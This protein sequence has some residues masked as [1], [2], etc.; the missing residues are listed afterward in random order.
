[1]VTFMLYKERDYS[2]VST[3][4]KTSNIKSINL[5]GDVH[6]KTVLMADDMIATGGTMLV[7]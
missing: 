4:A 5:L 1:M 3:S 2:V 7:L 6:G